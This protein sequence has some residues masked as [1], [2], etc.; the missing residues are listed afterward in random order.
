ME[1]VFRLSGLGF[2][3]YEIHMG[4]TSRRDTPDETIAENVIS[5]G[6]LVYGSYIHGI[7][8]RPEIA[9]EIITCLAQRKG[10]QIADG[11]FED[12]Q[13]FKEKQYDKLADTLRKYLDMNQ[14]YGML[15]D[16]DI[17]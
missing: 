2:Q 11:A 9:Q 4:S 8:D 13:S 6:N 14:I 17:H 1:G 16:A 5:D 3:G 12:Y 15:R 10:I 7:F